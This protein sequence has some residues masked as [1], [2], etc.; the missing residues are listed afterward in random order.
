MNLTTLP[1]SPEG[2]V[3][4]IHAISTNRIKIGF[5]TKPTERLK[6]LQTACPFPLQMLACWPGSE[7]R[8]KRVHRYLKQFRQVGEWFEVPPFIGYQIWQL[9]TQGNVTGG[10]KA[11]PISPLR[12]RPAGKLNVPPGYEVRVTFN[13][14]C[15][16]R[17]WREWVEEKG[18]KMMRRKYACY[19]GSEHYQ[20]LL[21]LA[22]EEQLREVEKLLPPA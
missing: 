3:Y 18:R 21:T 1:P 8:E 17:W 7:A 19:I 4:I 13:G 20:R 10:I 22:P 5:T 2:Y 15:I 11:K 9:V 12:L 14:T 16:Y 6:S